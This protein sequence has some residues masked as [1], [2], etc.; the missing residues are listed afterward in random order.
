MHSPLLSSTPSF[1][2]LLLSSCFFLSNVTRT[3]SS[4]K[5]YIIL[6][7]LLLL[8]LLFLL[9]FLLLLLLLLLL[10]DFDTRKDKREMDSRR[11]NLLFPLHFYLFGGELLAEEK[12]NRPPRVALDCFG[13]LPSKEKGE[14]SAR[15]FF[16][17]R[18]AGASFSIFGR[19]RS[20]ETSQ[21]RIS[22]IG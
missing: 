11:S 13:P 1:P 10:F 20:C 3:R 8:L 19:G 14:V 5:F 4:S 15:L 17:Y 7:L 9:L 16:D 12:W 22:F 21:M 18:L 2:P 6:I